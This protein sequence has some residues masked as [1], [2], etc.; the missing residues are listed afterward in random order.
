MLFDSHT[1]IN[2]ENY[3]DEQRAALIA[4]IAASDVSYAMDIGFDLA[5]SVQAVKDAQENDW[6]YAVVGFHPHDA[7]NMDDM[8]LELIGGLAKKDKVKAIGEIGLD[9]Y[10][11]HSE[12][13]V[14]QF[15][16]RRQIQLANQLKM[17]IVIHTREADQDTMAI[18]KEEGAFSAERQSWFPKRRG[19]EGKE[20]ADSRVYFDQYIQCTFSRILHRIILLILFRLLLDIQVKMPVPAYVSFLPAESHEVQDHCFLLLR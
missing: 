5:S 12:R 7:K 19:P 10:Y 4:E 2:N 9:Y 20:L 14:Q 11:D 16:F 15:W 8:T 3:T 18:L 13:D 1:H 6:C 17:P